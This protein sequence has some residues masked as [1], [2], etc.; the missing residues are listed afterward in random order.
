MQ[1]STEARGMGASALMVLPPYYMKTDGE[2]LLHYFS[3][4]AGRR[5]P[6]HGAGLR[7]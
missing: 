3:E 1:I 6:D 5:A 7:R 2:G 4:I